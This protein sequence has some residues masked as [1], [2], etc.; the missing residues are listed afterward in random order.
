MPF[1]KRTICKRCGSSRDGLSRRGLCGPCCCKG[2]SYGGSTVDL[3]RRKA[4]GR[5]GGAC[6]FGDAKAISGRKGGQAVVGRKKARAGRL[7]GRAKAL[8][9]GPHELWEIACSPSSNLCKAYQDLGL[10]ARRINLESGFDVYA[11]DTWERLRH[12]GRSGAKPGV[13]R[14][15]WV[16]LPCTVWSSWQRVNAS[17]SV[18]DA[19]CLKKRRARERQ[20]AMYIVDFIQWLFDN[21]FDIDVYWEWPDGCAGWS[22][23]ALLRLEKLLVDFDRSWLTAKIDGCRFGLHDVT[24]GHFLRKRWR[25]MTTDSRFADEFSAHFCHKRIRGVDVKHSAFYLL[26]MCTAMVSHFSEL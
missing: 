15:L 7:G 5:A 1:A 9:P 4:G 18:K 21:A 8:G 22:I 14:R 26:T 2:R 17:R 24:G 10:G 23:P 13:L 25:I 12:A 16:S 6:V 11:V 19:K 20:A 3:E